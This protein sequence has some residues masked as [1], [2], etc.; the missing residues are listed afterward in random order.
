MYPDFE[1]LLA[2]F[3]SAGVEYLVGGAHALAFHAHPRATRDLDLYVAPT[4]RNAA[5]VVRAIA[6]F[7]GGT[8]PSYVSV[9]NLL[10]PKVFVQL[11]VAPVRVDLLPKLFTTTFRAAWKRRVTARFGT[12]EANYLSRA[13]LIAEKRYFSR[14]QD[15]ADLEQLNRRARIK[16]P[17][18]R[19]R[20]KR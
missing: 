2:R 18:R 14:P 11:G 15:L 20:R 1:E 19:V 8:A 12:V 17:A 6:A 13:D 9:E 7:F 3:N 5:R 4:R 16:P 10:D